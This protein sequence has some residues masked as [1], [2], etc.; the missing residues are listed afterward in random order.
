MPDSALSA[1]TRGPANVF[2]VA[3]IALVL[4]MVAFWYTTSTRI[5]ALEAQLAALTETREHRLPE[6]NRPFQSEPVTSGLEARTNA[7]LT[8][9]EAHVPAFMTTPGTAD[10]TRRG[11][12]PAGDTAAA[13]GVQPT[14][15]A[16]M[17]KD[18]LQAL[19]RSLELTPERRAELGTGLEELLDSVWLEYV[20]FSKS[21]DADTTVL[22]RRYC[23][24]AHS[25]L[26]PE[27]AQRLGC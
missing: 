17:F 9:L 3:I 1:H 6:Q 21:P 8:D 11:T 5:T 12:W 16:Q 18:G 2:L 4:L 25:I 14:V 7:R 26:T 22:R 24:R 20:E 15:E 19:Y 27:E 10:T 23:D 13:G